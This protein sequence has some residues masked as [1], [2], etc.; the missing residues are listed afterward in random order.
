MLFALLVMGTG[1]QEAWSQK[2]ASE[3]LSPEAAA[4][5][6]PPECRGVFGQ[7]NNLEHCV[8]TLHDAA[9]GVTWTAAVDFQPTSQGG[10]FAEI[11]L[12][13]SVDAPVTVEMSDEACNTPYA[14]DLNADGSDELIYPSSGYAQINHWSILQVVEGE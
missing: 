8:V 11:R 13:H 9:L 2:H 14:A 6:R 3:P 12:T 5:E 4:S 1:S 10:C 7:E